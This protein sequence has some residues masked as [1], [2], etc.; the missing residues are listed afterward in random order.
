MFIV[1]TALWLMSPQNISA[2][3]TFVLAKDGKLLF[4]RNY[5]FFTGN[6]AIIVNPRNLAKTALVYPGE[7]PASWTAKYGSITFNQ[8]GREFPMGG[9]NE[10]GLVV[11]MMWLAEAEYPT[12]DS[13]PAVMEL[14]WIQY[15]L[16][17]SATIE[18]AKANNSLV[19]IMPSENHVHFLLLDHSGKAAVVEFIK[20]QT[21][22]Y[23]GDDLPVP[24]LTNK[25]YTECLKAMKDFQGFGGSKA[26]GTTI[27]D[28]D[29]FVT[30]AEA[31]KKPI[32]KSDLLD[33]AFEILDKVHC[34]YEESPT[35]WRIVYDPQK[36]E[37]HFQTLENPQLRTICF[38]DFSFNCSEKAKIADIQ[39]SAS[40]D[41]QKFFTDYSF[42]VN[43]ALVRKTFG[44]Y[45][46][47]GFGKEMPDMYLMVLA[48]Y[49]E[50]LIC[51]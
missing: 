46:K 12:P 44:I 32:G 15:I 39:S 41:I 38:K 22:F 34:G 24:A 1:L 5:D 3:S 49:P 40:S 21:L 50:S 47:V 31:I 17:T 19:R 36:L 10:A 9:M 4:G 7:N 20:G 11:E 26:I 30:L 23:S 2:C 33:R 18:E 27:N 29:R 8:V 28:P 42:A 51:K 37:I 13:R 25:P 6:G 48:G 14:Q 35:Q 16:D 45:K 43:D